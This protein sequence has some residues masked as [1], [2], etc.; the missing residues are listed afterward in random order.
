MES[1]EGQKPPS[2]EAPSEEQIREQIEEELKRVRVED[3]MLQT[4]SGLLNLAVRR[5]AKDDERDLPQAQLGI[6][7]VRAWVDLLP[8][9]AARQVRDALSELQVLFAKQAGG[10]DEGPE[11]GDGEE[12]E[13]GEEGEDAAPPPRRQP[14]AGEPRRGGKPPPDLWTP[15]GST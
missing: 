13:Q 8:E 6:D 1:G 5:I 3:L 10:G 9:Q 12:G 2:G 11:Q 15:P 7:A 14:A 4:I